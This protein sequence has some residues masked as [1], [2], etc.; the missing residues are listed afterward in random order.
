VVAYILEQTNQDELWDR[1]RQE[2][3][4]MAGTCSSGHLARLVNVLVG[5]H[6][7]IKIEISNYD[8]VKST[9]QQWMQNKATQDEHFENIIY[10]GND[11]LYTTLQSE[12]NGII[13]TL[14]YQLELDAVHVQSELEKIWEKMFGTKK[15]DG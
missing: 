7:D 14:S 6:P 13:E 5:F 10:Q 3:D 4:E 12:K 11:E 15:I 2:L 9:F 1:F 8:R